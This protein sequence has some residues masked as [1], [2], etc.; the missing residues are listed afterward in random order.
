MQKLRP[1]PNNFKWDPLYWAGTE[2]LTGVKTVAKVGGIWKPATGQQLTKDGFK[3][4]WC[5]KKC[6]HGFP[7]LGNFC[8]KPVDVPSLALSP[9]RFIF[10]RNL[11]LPQAAVFFCQSPLYPLRDRFWGHLKI[12][13]I[14]TCCDLQ[15]KKKVVVKAANLESKQSKQA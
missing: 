13:Q 1:F 8:R 11:S 9:T 12:Y 10:C 2:S 15:A 4:S 6:W 3:M 14:K 5:S 7:Q